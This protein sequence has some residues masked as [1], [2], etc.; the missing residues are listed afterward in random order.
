MTAFIMLILGGVAIGT[1]P[2]FMR[3]SEVTPTSAAFWRLL[4]AIPLLIIW[5]AYD[6]RKNKGAATPKLNMKDLK[7]FI[8]VSFFF[9]L[10]LT[11]WH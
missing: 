10:D 9:A 8:V 4:L 11:M 5:Q 3:F 7:P 2:I 1:A 6:I